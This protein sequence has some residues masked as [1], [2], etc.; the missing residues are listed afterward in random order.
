MRAV[1]IKTFIDKFSG[2]QVEKGARIEVD[3]ERLKTLTAHGVAEAIE[4]EAT[5][6]V[7]DTETEKPKATRRKAAKNDK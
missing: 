7:A 5:A 4:V 1:V 2:A 3:A 6:P